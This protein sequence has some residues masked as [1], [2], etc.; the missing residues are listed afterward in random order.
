MK[1]NLHLPRLPFYLAVG[2]IIFLC[3]CSRTA[4][5]DRHLARGQA[6]FKAE[7]YDKAE[8]EFLNVLRIERTNTLAMRQLGFGYHHQGR[9]LRAYAFLQKAYELDPQNVEVRLRLGA[10]LMAS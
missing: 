9:T 8:I 2:V 1:I 7:H 3:G 6:F 5:R 10:I 4:K